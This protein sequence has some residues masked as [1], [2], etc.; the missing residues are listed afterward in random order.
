MDD[1]DH[2]TRWIDIIGGHL[3]FA[4][5]TGKLLRSIHIG[6]DIGVVLPGPGGDV[7]VRE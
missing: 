2:R 4:D 7:P 3:H 6:G 5:E 1:G